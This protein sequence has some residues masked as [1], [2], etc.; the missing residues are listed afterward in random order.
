MKPNLVAV[1][2][3]SVLASE[4]VYAEQSDPVQATEKIIVT[5]N[6]IEQSLSEVAGSIA[7]ITG[8]ELER[9]GHTELYDAI[10]HEPGVSVTGGAGRPQNITIRGMSGNRIAIVRDGIMNADG[11][12]ANDLNDKVGRN[13]FDLSNVKRIEIVKGASSTLHGSGAIGGTVLIE[14][15]QADDYLLGKDFYADGAVT[16][17]GISDKY[18]LNSNLAFRYNNINSLLSL[19]YWEGK[20]TRNYQ[21][22]LYQRELEG[23]SVSYQLSHFLNDEWRLN[24]STEWYREQQYRH[25]GSGG[26]QPDGRWNLA[27]YYEDS[28]TDEWNI[29][30][31]VEYQP[32]DHQWL[33]EMTAKLYWRDT[34]DSQMIDRL[35]QRPNQNNL[36]IHRRTSE[37]KTFSDQQ[38]GI[39]FDISKQFHTANVQHTFVYGAG[40]ASNYYERTTQTHRAQSEQQEMTTHQPFTPARA[41][42]LGLYAR[43]NIELRDWD[44][45]FGLRFDTHRLKPDGNAIQNLIPEQSINS[46]QWSPSFSLA[47]KL[48]P[49]HQAY[50]SYSHGYRAPS[51]DKAYGFVSHE[52]IPLTPFIIIPNMDLKAETSDSFEIGHK[53]DS[54]QSQAYFAIFYQKFKNF[55]DIKEIGMDGPNTLKQYQNISGVETYGAELSL[56]KALTDVW[57]IAA[58]AGY[59]DGK[60]D[61]GEH[62]RSLTP[63]EGNVEVN[64]DSQG[65]TSAFAWNWASSMSRTPTCINEFNQAVSCASTES[66]HSFDWYITYQWTPAF[67]LSGSVINIFDNEYIRYQDVAGIAQENTR[68]STK[69]GRYFTINAKYQF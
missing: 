23:H 32:Y 44:I 35:Y 60:D 27:R 17:T 8:E 66:W 21:Q 46:H 47:K 2:V 26:I 24:W 49:H 45:A 15:M 22:D 12:G 52:H 51:Y 50:F 59:V 69:P 65:L 16:Y 34:Q 48:T 55:I 1:A 14:S 37:D 53:F 40:L 10:R 63:W 54:G 64:Y 4:I 43:D 56:S 7:V 31:G 6:K 61:N 9:R 28:H 57:Q 68:Y 3:L 20:H 19:A 36:L 5:A 25:E 41:Y 58:K 39:K 13:S 29:S 42:N 62:I 11:Y 30:L 67:T 38:L 18:K 33:D